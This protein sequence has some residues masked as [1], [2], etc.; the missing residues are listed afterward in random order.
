M[1]LDKQEA[2]FVSDAGLKFVGYAG[3][4]R[5]SPA[6]WNRIKMSESLITVD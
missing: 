6:G 4:K 2:V 3:R 1:K 5:Q